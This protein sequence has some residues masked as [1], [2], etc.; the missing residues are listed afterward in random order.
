MNKEV[1]D[2]ISMEY[3]RIRWS[4]WNPV[5][6]LLAMQVRLIAVIIPCYLGQL[7]TWRH[8]D[9]DAHRTG[10]RLEF[11]HMVRFQTDSCLISFHHTS[12]YD[13]SFYIICT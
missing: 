4:F 6:T 9:I 12:W 8:Y 11:Q 10:V 13:T 3:A 5:P 7:S 2:E 1:Y